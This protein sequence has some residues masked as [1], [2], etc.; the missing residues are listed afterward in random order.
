MMDKVTGGAQSD[1][2]WQPCRQSSVW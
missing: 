2:Y 1:Q